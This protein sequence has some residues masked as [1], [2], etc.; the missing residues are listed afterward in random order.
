VEIAARDIEAVETD[1]LSI[2]T[3]QSHIS[4]TREKWHGN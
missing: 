2:S 1:S 4:E 3:A